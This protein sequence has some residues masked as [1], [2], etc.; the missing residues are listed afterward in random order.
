[1][2]KLWILTNTDFVS[3]GK[4]YNSA[5]HISIAIHADLWYN[6]K[7]FARPAIPWHGARITTG[8][9][10]GQRAEDSRR[11]RVPYTSINAKNQ[12]LF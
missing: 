5:R 10:D 9:S 4:F 3:T 7:D 6:N 2:Q 12:T 11:S 1:M 8:L